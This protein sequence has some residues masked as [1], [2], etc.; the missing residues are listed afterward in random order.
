MLIA[1][2]LGLAFGSLFATIA[3]RWVPEANTP[4]GLLLLGGAGTPLVLVWLWGAM[5]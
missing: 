3:A 4:M 5:R 2:V 1:T